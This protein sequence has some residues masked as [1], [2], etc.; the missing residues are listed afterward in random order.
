MKELHCKLC[1]S[2]NIIRKDETYICEACNKEYSAMEIIQLTEDDIEEEHKTLK[3]TKGSIAEKSRDF[4]KV[5][6]LSYY[7]NLLKANP[8]DWQGQFFVVY[9]N[10]Q[11]AGINDIIPSISRLIN[12][13]HKSLKLI[14]EN[15]ESSQKQ[16]EALMEISGAFQIIAATFK[17]TNSNKKTDNEALIART[18]KEWV[19][20][21]E[22]LAKM[23]YSFGDEVKDMFGVYVLQSNSEMSATEVFA[24]YKKRWGI[25]TFY[26][27]LKNIGDFNNLMVQD[28]YK[29]QGLAFIMLI[30]GQIHQK[31]ISAVKKL[32]NNT[33]IHFQLGGNSVNGE[34]FA[35]LAFTPFLN[36]LL[37]LFR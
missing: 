6:S 13:S 5:K 31:M 23:F 12:A 1:G 24:N 18:N 4:H 30:T 26:Q 25:E 37:L 34:P 7:E 27:Y 16:M 2:G 22:H 9:L 17:N 28:Y 32:H 15:V 19:L 10:A 21:V 14:K 20:R 8:D 35:A 11:N 33:I 29:E 3:L 36:L